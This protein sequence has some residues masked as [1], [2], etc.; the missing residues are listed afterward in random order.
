MRPAPEER[1]RR[2]WSR[3]WGPLP[4]T[5]SSS[6]TFADAARSLRRL[7]RS[8]LGCHSLQAKRDCW[9]R[10]YKGDLSLLTSPGTPS[11]HVSLPN[12]YS[13]VSV[14]PIDPSRAE[15]LIDLVAPVAGRARR[16]KPGSRLNSIMKT[17][18]TR[19]LVKGRTTQLLCQMTTRQIAGSG[20]RVEWIRHSLSACS[21]AGTGSWVR[22]HGLRQPGDRRRGTQRAKQPP[23]PGPLRTDRYACCPGWSPGHINEQLYSRRPLYRQ[24]PD[25]A[26]RR[27]TSPLWRHAPSARLSAYSLS[28]LYS[29]GRP[30]QMIAADTDQPLPGGCRALRRSHGSRTRRSGLERFLGTPRKPLW[31]GHRTVLP[32]RDDSPVP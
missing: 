29:T 20:A 23:R 28:I 6:M 13:K 8:R 15:Q 30:A 9:T 18:F 3:R 21:R 5:G 24:L 25:S 7:L 1:T 16:P 11:K 27:S 12:R 32:N 17:H 19:V 14:W 22:I 2:W 4:K 31:P 10:R 26:D